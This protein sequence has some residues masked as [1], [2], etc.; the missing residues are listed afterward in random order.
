MWGGGANE[1]DEVQRLI[2][3]F[4]ARRAMNSPAAKLDVLMDLERLGDPR[5]V[6]F[7]LQVLGDPSESADV[8]MH[9]L[10][11]LRSGPLTADE[12]PTV[13]RAFGELML[14]GSSI[15]LRLQAAVALGEFTDIEGVVR[16]L[17]SLALEP[18][19]LLDLRYSAFTS[20]EPAGCTAEC[21]VVLRQLSHDEMLGRSAQ[22]ALARWHVDYRE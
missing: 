19:E 22:S 9:A 6:P 10:K 15:E 20:L 5:L 1:M 8:R 3:A 11:R 18:Q 17:G 7:L 21:V 13:A 16:A 4:G 2:Q 14:H 12:R